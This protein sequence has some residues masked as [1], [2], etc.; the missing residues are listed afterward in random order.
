M[1][2]IL[3]TPRRGDTVGMTPEVREQII[4]GLMESFVYVGAKDFDEAMRTVETITVSFLECVRSMDSVDKLRQLLDET[5]LTK[6]QEKTLVGMAHSVPA[7]IGMLIR[8]AAEVAESTLPQQR[9][10][11]PAVGFYIREKVLDFIVTAMR[12][13]YS[14]TEAKQY[15]MSRFSLSRATVQ[16]IWKE[17]SAGSVPDAAD[18]FEAMQD[19]TLKN[20]ILKTKVRKV[21]PDLARQ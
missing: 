1:G 16:R 7:V 11:R 5:E 15:A 14:L 3:I 8:Q 17:R 10:G 18:I 12:N 6:R 13:G 4:S 9:A 21:E 2:V 19:G 20:S